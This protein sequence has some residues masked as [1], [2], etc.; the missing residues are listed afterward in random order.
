MS[1]CPSCVLLNDWFEV[2]AMHGS[3]E[4]VDGEEVLDRGN[5]GR[6]TKDSLGTIGH[7]NHIFEYGVSYYKEH[8]WLQG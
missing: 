6:F 5:L 3:R 2:L 1:V 4:M 7:E 8:M